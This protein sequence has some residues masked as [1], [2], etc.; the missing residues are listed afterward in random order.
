M[1][2]FEIFG[3]KVSLGTMIYQATLFT[4]L[5]FILKKKFL[6]KLVT[7][8]E[9]RRESIENQLK[10]V[11]ELKKEAESEIMKQREISKKSNYEAKILISKAQDEAVQIIKTARNEA[12]MIRREAY[13]KKVQ[14]TKQRGAS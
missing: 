10:L 1:G 14:E 3:M 7:A 11:E 5:I 13:G 2:E 6:E 8:M 9:N 4:I 12:Y